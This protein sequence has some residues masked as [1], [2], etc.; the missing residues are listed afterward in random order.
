MHAG[1]PAPNAEHLAGGPASAPA[2][3]SVDPEE[4]AKFARLA[5]RWWDPAG[6][7]AALHRLN[8]ARIAFVRD[9]VVAHW[10]RDLRNDRP[11]A[12]L[13][14][15][16]VGCGGGLLA[17]PMTRLG[18]QVTAIDAVPRNVAVA[19][20]HAE[21]QNLKID[22]RTG[23]AESLAATGE[24]YDVVLTMEVVEHVA[25]RRAFLRACAA[26]VAP[27]GMLFVA[28]L[29]RTAK[30]FAFA[31]L[32]AEYLLG[33]LPRGTHDW[34]KFVRPSE[35]AVDLRSNGLEI[36]EMT[37]VGYDIATDRWRLTDDLSVNYMLVAKR[38]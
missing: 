14:L 35:V 11:V 6:E 30:A 19:R 34:R 9:K 33:W 20:L 3:A 26:L 12:G 13:R 28:T 18:A 1:T 16:D 29:N 22:Y 10:N 27:G 15:L 38:A 5:D 21:R 36:V 24:R 31:I 32:G 37:G 23:T 4:T 25:D 8:P 17:E 2:T 7:F